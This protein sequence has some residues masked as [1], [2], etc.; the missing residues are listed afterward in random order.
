MRA[1]LNFTMYLFSRGD[2][3]YDVVSDDIITELGIAELP[4]LNAKGLYSH[5]K[6]QKS[7]IR[8]M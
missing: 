8:A 2:N 7:Q 5:D 4:P 6:Y 3:L 1:I